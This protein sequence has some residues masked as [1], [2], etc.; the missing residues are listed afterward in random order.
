MAE[1]EPRCEQL[2]AENAALRTRIYTTKEYQVATVQEVENLKA[3][4]MALV[5]RKVNFGAHSVSYYL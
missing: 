4:K 3:E 1:D 5:E 2:R